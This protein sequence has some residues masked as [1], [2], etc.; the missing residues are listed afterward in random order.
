MQTPYALRSQTN[1]VSFMYFLLNSTTDA[2]SFC[3][4]VHEEIVE[5]VLGHMQMNARLHRK[6]NCTFLA[7]YQEEGNT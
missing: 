3:A 4:Q 1:F 5:K 2:K 6:H 7:L